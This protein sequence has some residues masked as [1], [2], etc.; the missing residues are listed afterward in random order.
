[1]MR[2]PSQSFSILT[3][4]ALVLAHVAQP[5]AAPSRHRARLHAAR[6][7]KV[8]AHAGAGRSKTTARG[9]APAMPASR[10]T[11]APAISACTSAIGPQCRARS[12]AAS[13]T[14][15]AFN[16]E[17]KAPSNGASSA[18]ER[19]AACR[20]PPSCAGTS[21][22][23]DRTTRPNR[24]TGRVLVVTRLGPGGVCHVGYVDGRANPNANE[25]A[26]QIA[27]EQRAHVQVRHRQAGGARHQGQGFQRALRRRLNK[28]PANGRACRWNIRIRI[29]CSRRRRPCRE[30]CR[31]TAPTSGRPP[32]RRAPVELDR[33][34]VVRQR[35]DH[36]ALQPALREIAA[37]RGEQAAAEAE[38]LIL[39]AQIELVDLAVIEQ[40]ART[41]AAVVGVAGDLV[42]E[43]QDARC[44]C[45]CGSRCPTS[46]GRGA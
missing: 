7:R 5:A 21:R 12:R 14:L 6:S 34:I 35:P 22:R 46:R 30:S 8:Q 39:R 36:Q 17:G 27:D 23:I 38:P 32:C 4:F 42:A 37:R 10:S 26:R 15:A 19:Q 18:A 44:G 41:V 9:A 33:R 1:M 28:S 40:A 11:S 25:L 43:R 31:R 29:S 3:A 16:S 20:S 24:S 13:Q 2:G 45:P